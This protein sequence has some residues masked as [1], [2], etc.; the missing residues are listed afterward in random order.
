MGTI[1]AAVVL[2]VDMDEKDCSSPQDLAEFTRQ[3]L[4]QAGYGMTKAP[5]LVTFQGQIKQVRI[6]DVMEA[7]VAAGNGYLWT[8]VT[9]KAYTQRGIYTEKQLRQIQREE[10]WEKENGDS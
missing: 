8:D 6:V 7:G 2:F 5:L 10:K 9:T 4:Y 3:G 1:R